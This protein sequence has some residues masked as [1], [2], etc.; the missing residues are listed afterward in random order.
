MA[1][2]GGYRNQVSANHGRIGILGRGPAENGYHRGNANI[3][4]SRNQVSAG[5]P[6][7]G[8]P[9][10]RPISTRGG[11]GSIGRGGSFSSG[12]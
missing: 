6:R 10:S 2:V 3:A 7:M 4:G 5:R 11:F 12:S 9:N 1:H 8:T